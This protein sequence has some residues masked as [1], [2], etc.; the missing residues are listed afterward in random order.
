MN[1]QFEMLYD[2]VYLSLLDLSSAEPWKL[3]EL[4]WTTM[5]G[6]AIKESKPQLKDFKL[7]WRPNAKRVIIV[8]SDEHG[9]SYMI[10][11][12]IADGSWNANKD[13]VTQ[14]ILLK[15]IQSAPDTAIYTFSTGL[16][17]NSSMPYGET[18]W[19]ALS[20]AS[21]GKWFKLQHS[22]VEMYSNLM[23]IIDEEVCGE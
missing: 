20:D 3:D 15:M 18:G 21:G 12:A 8:F 11:K 14:L 10:P 6:N 4:T 1:G 23:E 22:P 2:A 5:V 17:K 7:S 13:G 9:Q 19:E 16:S